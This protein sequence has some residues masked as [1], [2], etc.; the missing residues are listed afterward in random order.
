MA[1]RY[2]HRLSHL[3][4]QGVGGRFERSLLQRVAGT[5]LSRIPLP[6]DNPFINQFFNLLFGGKERS[7][8]LLRF[9]T[10]QSWQTDQCVMA[11]RFRLVESFDMG[12]R[13]QQ[14]QAPTLILH[15]E[16]DLL[17]S[18]KSLA[19]LHEGIL[20]SELIHLPGAGHLGFVTQ[21][22]RVADEVLRFLA[23]TTT[24]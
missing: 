16:R 5:V 18:P 8:P 13:L 2:P 11:H 9:V 20:D 4:L 12:E 21:P 22:E 15:G 17:V 6:T 3:V 14:V 7:K 19:V 1:A 24:D 23:T 10:R